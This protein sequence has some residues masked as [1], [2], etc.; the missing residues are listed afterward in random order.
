ML[1]IIGARTRRLW[2][3]LRTQ[4]AKTLK[5]GRRCVLIVPEQY[6]LQAECDLIHDLSLPGFFDI[7]VFSLPRFVQRLFA[8]CGSSRVRID[9]NGKNIALAQ[10]LLQ[11]KDNLKYYSHSVTRRG[12]I[13]QSSDWIADMKRAQIT[14]ERLSTYA[15]TLEKS[16][17]ADKLSDLAQ[18]YSGYSDI[19]ADKFVDG[20]DVL[21]AA[22]DAVQTSKLVQNADVL[23]YG[24]DI[25]TDDFARLLC[26][27]TRSCSNAWV[28]LVMD[29]EQASDGDCF[30]PVRSSAERLRDHLRDAHL[31]REW[32]WLDNVKP[33]APEDVCALEA[34]LLRPTP[35][36][37]SKVPQHISLFEAASPFAEAH[38]IAQEI[39]ACSKRG[40][41]YSDIAVLCGNLDDYA[42]V[43][44]TVLRQYDIPIYVA[45]KEPLLSHGIVRLLLSAVRA[46]T[47]N[48]RT[49]D[50]LSVIK[51]GFTP[52]SRDEIWQLENYALAYG[53]VGSRWT[54]TFT[55]GSDDEREVP[56]QA[57]QKIY[58]ALEHL[59][60]S[61]HDA[62]DAFQS[63]QALM[64]LLTECDAFHILVKQEEALLHAGMTDQAV[65]TRQVWTRLLALFEQMHE[66][67][68]GAPIPGETVASWIEAGLMEEGISSLPPSGGCVTIGEIGNLII[69][70][71]KIT[72]ACGLNSEGNA[73]GD[74]SLLTD[75]EKQTAC[76]DMKAY[77][78]MNAEEHDLMG[79]L[80]LWKVLSSPREYL[81]LSHSQANQAGE[82]LRPLPMLSTIRRIFPALTVLGTVDSVQGALHPLA[83]QPA[84][85]AVGTHI[86]SGDLQGEWLDA[87]RWIWKQENC[88][89]Q[90]TA[91]LSASRND[92][93][94]EKLTPSMACT[95]FNDQIVSISR[96]ESYASCPYQHFV[97]HGLRPQERKEWK[98]DQRDKGVF[99]HAAMEGFIN[100]LSG[101]P[102]WPNISRTDCD[103][104]MEE[105][106]LPLTEQWKELAIG[107]N[108]RAHREGERYLRICKR[109]AWVFTKGATKSKFRPESGEVSFGYPGGPPPLTLCLSDGSKVSVRGRI[110][111]ID[112]FDNGES[113]YLRVVDYKSGMKKLDPSQINIGIQLQLLLYL[114]AALACDENA[115]PAGAFYQ[116]M[117]D[118]LVNSDKQSMIESE[119]AKRLCLK[120]VMLSDVQVIEWM[121]ASK[122]PISIE[123]VLNKDNLPRKNK[124]VCTLE[125]LYRLIERAHKTAV[126][127]T[128]EIRSGNI[129][130]APVYERDEAISCKNCDFAGVCRRDSRNPQSDR[131]LEKVQLSDL[132]K[133]AQS[134]QSE[135]S[136]NK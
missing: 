16:A 121:D 124:L 90:M 109:V 2:P 1:T 77:L 128:E 59:Q 4:A 97:L 87:A 45:A 31:R 133:A 70:E 47:G 38:Y 24:F 108:A 25:I 72:F 20:E 28:Y 5:E 58:S 23:V 13:K 15:D 131:M 52:L 51:S 135:N 48:Y 40:I 49:E 55:R 50:V 69:P 125:E 85:D 39:T 46:V 43:L 63:L 126:H 113:V 123:N 30:A 84:L 80:D 42:A 6:T 78:G 33:D 32:L 95:L 103:S 98:I 3:H 66:I 68:G 35:Q 18:I 17:Y 82:A 29:R 10:A 65:R 91:L 75:E 57:R 100:A 134:D 60:S 114:E 54:K 64:N 11:C 81:Y 7:E 115:L 118:P 127:L 132:V 105:A 129:G 83:L 99:Y 34:C 44:D 67:A 74:S 119:I 22:I 61:L 8:I 27:I 86:R 136:S 71:P 12:F 107:D 89:S 21:A 79:D 102:N 56:E 112:R 53:I 101:N 110:D 92:R 93:Q 106:M 37:Y 117:I 76:A 122:P 19:L 41:A 104:L 36:P 88:R 26:A 111:R 130:A 14:P 9:N 73:S 116:W 62:E 96:L 120:G 94:Q